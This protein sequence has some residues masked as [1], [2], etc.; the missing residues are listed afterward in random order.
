MKTNKT[1]LSLPIEFMDV[2]ERSVIIKIAEEN[3]DEEGKL[4]I[5]KNEPGKF[6]FDLKFKINFIKD[7]ETIQFIGYGDFV[8]KLGGFKAAA[9]PVLTF[10]VPVTILVFLI[11]FSKILK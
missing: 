11:D 4:K 6:H 2:E 10:F 3:I 8:S 9:T 5:I 7:L 1:I